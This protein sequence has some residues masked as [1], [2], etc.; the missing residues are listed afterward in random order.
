MRCIGIGIGLG[1]SKR[2]KRKLSDELFQ[3]F[4]I[5]FDGKYS[6][7]NLKSEINDD[8][9][10]VTLGENVKYGRLYNTFSVNDV[11]GLAPTG[12]HVP[13]R[14]EFDT[15]FTELGGASIAGGKMKEAGTINWT[16]PN[17]GA[18][19]S[20]GFTALP[21]GFRG[22]DGY[23][24]VESGE[25]NLHGIY[26]TATLFGGNNRSLFLSYNA[27]DASI[28]NL[29][30]GQAASVRLIRDDLTGYEEGET[31]T[32]LNGNVYDT[33]QIGDQ[34]W[35][36]Q[37]WACTKYANGDDI[38]NVTDGAA[39]AALETG[40]YCN[41]DNDADY[42]FEA[43]QMWTSKH[44]PATTRAKFTLPATQ[45]YTDA[46][47]DEFWTD[48]Q[49]DVVRLVSYDPARTFVQYSDFPPHDIQKIGIPKAD[50]VFTEADENELS[51]FFRLPW[52]RFGYFNYFGWWKANMLADEVRVWEAEP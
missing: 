45:A 41:Y 38:P 31:V 49:C 12:W 9:I 37:N 17:T 20:S 36:V 28:G 5:L 16:T 8:V 27:S 19:N 11:R 43:E 44:I 40:A 34:V 24:D 3:Q 51:R 4:A 2:K 33:V 30:P 52:W 10:T 23:F 25:I 22:E 29:Q 14:T 1:F 35:M 15:L 13:I 42:V 39:W 46:D 32:D 21:G 26:L 7:G 48:G 6:D 18:D 50:A 47:T